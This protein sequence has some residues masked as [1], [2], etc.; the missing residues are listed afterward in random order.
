MHVGMRLRCQNKE[1]FFFLAIYLSKI[2]ERTV[3]YVGCILQ[4]IRSVCWREGFHGYLKVQV[5]YVICP[6]GHGRKTYLTW[7]SCRKYYT[8]WACPLFMCSEL[9]AVNTDVGSENIGRGS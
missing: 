8:D 4:F 2:P 7:A 3:M 9:V 6:W 1:L 5:E